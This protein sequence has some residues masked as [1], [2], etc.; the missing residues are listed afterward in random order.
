MDIH[1][2]ARIFTHQR[3]RCSG[4]V[5][6]DVREKDGVEIAHADAAGPQLLPQ[7]LER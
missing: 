2:E 3:P 7:S 4:V 1:G 5:Q 6:V